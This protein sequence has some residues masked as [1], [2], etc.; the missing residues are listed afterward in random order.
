MVRYGFLELGLNRVGLNVWA[1]NDRAIAAYRKAGF[2]EEGRT[3]EAVWHDGRFHD[4]LSMGLLA[5][6]WDANR[7]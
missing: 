3:R 6:E 7:G 1:Y 4:E 5:S 2:V